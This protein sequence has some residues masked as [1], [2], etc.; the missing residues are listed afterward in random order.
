[1]EHLATIYTHIQNELA[2]GPKDMHPFRRPEATISQAKGLRPQRKL[3]IGE[4]CQPYN[5]G[6]T[7]DHSVRLQ[8]V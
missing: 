5:W 8:Y 6:A 4:K 3:H 7:H 1:M 2:D